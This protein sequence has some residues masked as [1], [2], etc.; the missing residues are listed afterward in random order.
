MGKVHHVNPRSK[1]SVGTQSVN[2][3]L[4]LLAMFTDEKPSWS[5]TRLAE[6][7]SLNKTTAH[8]LLSALAEQGLLS[9]DE[10][11]ERYR[12]GPQAIVMGGRAMRANPVREVA[13]P[14]LATLARATGETATLDVLVGRDVLIVEDFAAGRVLGGGEVGMLY[15]AHA[16]GTGTVLLALTEPAPELPETLAALTPKTVTDATAL[17]RELAEA[18]ERG[19][20]VNVEELERGFA[21]AGAPVRDGSGR[22]V[23]AIG[24]GGPVTRMDFDTMVEPVVAAARRTSA[25]LGA[26]EA[27]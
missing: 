3:A 11:A 21:A 1:S 14:E 12:L 15:P 13:R 20:A 2:R 7:A 27:T 25:R 19:W 8:R 17:R 10:E 26:M 9:W 24:L 23:A 18:A 5:L 6:A 4:S 22:V 16:T